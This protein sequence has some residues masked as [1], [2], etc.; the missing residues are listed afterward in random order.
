MNHEPA[1]QEEDNDAR[2]KDPLV[3]AGTALHHADRV[4]A[5]AQR[6]GDAVQ[7]LLRVL[8]RL[9]LLAQ[10]PQHGLPARDEV[11]QGMVGVVEEVL[12]AKGMRLA[13]VVAGA[14]RQRG[15][16]GACVP[17][18][19]RRVRHRRRRRGAGVGV[20]RRGVVRSPAEEL[21][22][23][24]VVL[25]FFAGSLDDVELGAELGQLLAE[26]L[27]SLVGL[28][29]LLGDQFLARE[30]V[31]FV[32]RLGKGG[33]GDGD[34]ANVGGRGRGLGLEVGEVTADGL[35]L[36]QHRVVGDVLSTQRSYCLVRGFGIARPR[37]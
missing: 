7:P 15:A 14:R 37:R 26:A 2:D 21:G 28:L 18:L 30:A 34:A 36:P 17:G 16:V 4:A 5:H 25:R 9:A 33:E 6:V 8:E 10:V 20:L 22:A 12:L 27:D 29:L 24:V 3:L 32:E 35:A 13:E 11:V 23:V 1:K 31:V 19:E